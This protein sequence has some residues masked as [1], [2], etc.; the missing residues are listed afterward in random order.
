MGHTQHVSTACPGD[1]PMLLA[2]GNMCHQ[3]HV[4]GMVCL[5]EKG[6]LKRLPA[7]TPSS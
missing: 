4:G 6:L 1:L 7:P 5:A 2:L 3:T